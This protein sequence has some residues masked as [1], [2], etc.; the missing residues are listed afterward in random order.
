MA[1]T[2][3]VDSLVNRG[4]LRR[5]FI[6]LCKTCPYEQANPDDCPLHFL[7]EKPADE[8]S[9]WID[10]LTDFQFMELYQR[11]WRCS[12]AKQDRTAS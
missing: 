12:H 3:S 2:C 9:Y 1:T 4:S 10:S 5:L 7:R 11:H 6:E 8:S